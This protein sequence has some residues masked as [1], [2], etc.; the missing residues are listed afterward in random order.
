MLNIVQDFL[1]KADAGAEGGNTP[2]EE[3]LEQALDLRTKVA[4]VESE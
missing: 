3:V 4:I 1:E 2:N